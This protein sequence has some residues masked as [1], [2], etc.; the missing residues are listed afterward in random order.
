MMEEEIYDEVINAKLSERGL[1]LP[2][3]CIEECSLETIHVRI[4]FC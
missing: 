4:H 2:P 1:H 3:E